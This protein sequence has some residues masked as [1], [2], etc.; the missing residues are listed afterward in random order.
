MNTVRNVGKSLQDHHT[1]MALTA[2][3]PWPNKTKI[4][5]DTVSVKANRKTI[6]FI[7]CWCL[8]KALIAMFKRN[9]AIIITIIYSQT[10]I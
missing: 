5:E 3:C 2:Y 6:P 9:M 7:C 10:K 1:S 8:Q 4:I